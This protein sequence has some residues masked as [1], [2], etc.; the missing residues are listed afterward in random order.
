MSKLF[1]SPNTFPQSYNPYFYLNNEGF[2]LQCSDD[3]KKVTIPDSTTGTI[4]GYQ[5][6]DPRTYS[7]T[8]AQR[9]VFDR[10]PLQVKNTQPLQNL[11]TDENVAGSHVGFYND[12]ESIKG[13]QILYYIDTSTALP[14]TNPEYTLTSYVE[15]S[16]YH[17]PMGTNYAY[18]NKIPAFQNNRNIV[19]YSFDQDQLG[20][21]EDLSSIQSRKMNQTSYGS[22]RVY[23]NPE[24]Y[25]H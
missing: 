17:N 13:G 6:M 12:Y 7:T 25:F 4:S 24:K 3:F 21:R 18:Y 5:S 16:I 11:Y 9:M 15:P 2:S 20:F 8:R 14:Y 10:P 22:L 23:S 19:Q 1:I